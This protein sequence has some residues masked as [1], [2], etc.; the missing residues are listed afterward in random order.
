MQP[1]ELAKIFAANVKS[2]R[3][4]LGMSQAELAERLGTQQPHVAR[5]E[6]GH[7]TPRLAII[8][9]MAEAL[10]TTPASLLTADAFSTQKIAC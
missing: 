10:S 8:A 7:A 1:V 5:F 2:R 3:L 6:N 4:E 9:K